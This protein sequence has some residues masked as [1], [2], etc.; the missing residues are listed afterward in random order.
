MTWNSEAELTFAL[1]IALENIFLYVKPPCKT[2]IILINSAPFYR[3]LN[4]KKLIFLSSTHT[5]NGKD[6]FTMTDFCVIRTI[7][8]FHRIP[9]AHVLLAETLSHKPLN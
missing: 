7:S 6:S 8:L 3:K 4:F 1:A 2:L 5:I 9:V